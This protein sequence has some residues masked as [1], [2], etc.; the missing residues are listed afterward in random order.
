MLLATARLLMAVVLAIAR[1]QYA[2]ELLRYLIAHTLATCVI[3]LIWFAGSYLSPQSEIEQ[4]MLFSSKLIAL[5]YSGY[6]VLEVL[7]GLAAIGVPVP[8]WIRERL[9]AVLRNGKREGGQQ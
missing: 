5:W 2:K 8:A 9:D 3:L 7:D 4:V 6:C 1:K